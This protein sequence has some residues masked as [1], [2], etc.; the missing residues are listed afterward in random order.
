MPI[1]VKRS[2]VRAENVL[3]SNVNKEDINGIEYHLPLYSVYVF[4]KEIPIILFYAANGMDWALSYLGVDNVLG[5]VE[6]LNKSDNDKYLYFQ[7]SSKC[8]I[9]VNKEVFL[10]YP[11]IQSIVGGLLYVTTNRITIPDLNNK[12]IWIKKLSNNNTVEKGKDILVFFNRLNHLI[13]DVKPFKLL[14]RFV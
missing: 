10:K 11:Y 13:A 4:K 1:A 9:E 5:F 14:E 7:I 6:D 12:D 2:G 3:K 8:Y